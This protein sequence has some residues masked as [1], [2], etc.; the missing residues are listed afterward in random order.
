[1][2]TFDYEASAELFAARGHPGLRYQRFTQAAEAIWYAIEKTAAQSACGV[3]I[4]GQRS[5]L[6]RH[7]DPRALCERALPFEPQQARNMSVA[8]DVALERSTLDA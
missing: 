1:M 5:T 4:R 3:I 6:Q 7:A 8:A 2:P